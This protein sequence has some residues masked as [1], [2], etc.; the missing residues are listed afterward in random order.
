MPLSPEDSPRAS[1]AVLFSCPLAFCVSGLF[2]FWGGHGV[3]LGGQAATS[4]HTLL[5]IMRTCADFD[6]GSPLTTGSST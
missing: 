3:V 1:I 6:S 2:S 5:P 4:G